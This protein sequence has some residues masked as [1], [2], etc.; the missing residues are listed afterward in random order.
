[1]ATQSQTQS[2]RS[3]IRSRGVQLFAAA[4]FLALM[5][6]PGQLQAETIILKNGQVIS[7]KIVGQSRTQVRI[8]T[9]NGVRAVPK[10]QIRR[11]SYESAAE[12]RRKQAEAE[13]RRQQK[14]EEAER[15]R[16]AEQE[17]AE[18]ARKAE[19]EAESETNNAATDD[20]GLS[21]AGFALRNAVAPGWG[22]FAN[23]QP[24][25]GGTYAAL[26]AGALIYAYTTRVDA[27]AAREEN[28]SQVEFNTLLS[29]APGT[30]DSSTR[31]A[32]GFLTNQAASGPYQDKI[33]RHNQSLQLLGLVY[34]AQLAH[35]AAL[36]PGWPTPGTVSW[37]LPE[38][39]GRISLGLVGASRQSAPLFGAG[40]SWR[41]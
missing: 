17:A 24:I 19:A 3:P 22:F 14:L 33:D 34:V 8:D 26:T 10:T 21:Y 2:P 40:L 6:L 12:V 39:S 16:K 35:T 38:S 27:L 4:A 37:D 36:Y 15:Q 5:L 1:M 25:L 11:I 41:F 28:F 13:R 23:D 32:L 30:A 20:S 7:G 29:L 31:L 9:G 18:A